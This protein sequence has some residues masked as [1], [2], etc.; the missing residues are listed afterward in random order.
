VF[1]D[2]RILVVLVAHVVDD[3]LALIGAQLSHR[4]VVAHLH[5]DDDVGVGRVP[6]DDLE[7]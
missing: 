1:E 3:E 6:R 5:D 2:A 7:L 4:L